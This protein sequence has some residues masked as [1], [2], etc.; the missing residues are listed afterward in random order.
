MKNLSESGDFLMANQPTYEELKQM[1]KGLEKEIVEYKRSEAVL[2][3]S[4][5]ELSA[6]LSSA[7]LIMMVVDQNRQVR[8]VSNAL[9]QFT[10]RQ[11]EEV[12]GKRGG[13]ALRCIHH[14]D[15]PKGCG[16]GPVCQTC[17]VRRVVLDTFKT[18]DCYHQV[19][20]KLSFEGDKVEERVLLVSTALLDTPEN[21]ALVC[22]EDITER[23]HAEEELRKSEERYRTILEVNPDPVVLYDLEGR[24]TY[25][26]PAFEQGFGWSFYELA[27]KRI[28]FVPEENWPETKDAIEKMFS[29]EKINSFETRRLTKE[30]KILDVQISASLFLYR[31]GKREGS[32]VTLRDITERKQAEEALQR[33]HAELEMRVEE[34][35]AELA[36]ANKE[37]RAEILVR[38]QAEKALLKAKEAAEAASQAKSNFLATMSHELRT[39]LNSVIGF[40]EILADQS[41]GELNERQAKYAGSILNSGR[42]LL[43]LVNDVLDLAEV[44]AGKTE[45]KLSEFDASGAIHSVLGSAESLADKKNIALMIELEESLPLI[46]ADEAKFNQIIYNLISNAVK[47]TPEGGSITLAARHLSFVNGHLQTRDGQKTS[48]PMTN[49]Q[50]LMTHR[51][52]LEISVSDT[53][54]GIKPEDQKC[55]FGK[56]E[57]IDSSYSREHEGTGLGLALT[58][59]L[60]ELHE[61]RIWVESEGEGRGSRF[62]FVLP[63]KP[64]YL[65]GDEIEAKEDLSIPNIANHKNLL[66]HLNRAISLSGRHHRSFTLCRL[67]TDME[68]TKEN[69]LAMEDALVKEKRSYDYLGKDEGGRWYLIMLEADRKKAKVASDRFEKKLESILE[70]R[71]ISFSTATFPQDGESADALLARVREP[72]IMQ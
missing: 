71:K 54:I 51:N 4:Q 2:K 58:R 27:G 60:M 9:M 10:G 20:A 13:E 72:A 40:S 24:V 34:R 21:M 32:I 3:D 35:T 65:E 5:M 63:I 18:G 25:V 28:D 53:G 11:E 17:Q 33:A 29:G 59:K 45:L 19:E 8:Q 66:I 67:H 39:P 68:Q 14:L 7:P 56:F 23:K 30:R 15:D 22:I 52:L 61:G 36:K 44:E 55:I 37:L 69:V 41:F 42:H 64:Q 1:I 50:E 16:Y 48:L 62:S 57:Q 70:G 26:N 47:F 49:D 38:K 43:D 12:I 46:T 6:I 31:D